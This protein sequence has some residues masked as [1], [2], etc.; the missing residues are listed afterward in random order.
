MIQSE[1]IAT[2]S[3]GIGPSHF[4][5]LALGQYLKVFSV[6]KGQKP[7][8]DSAL[9]HQISDSGNTNTPSPPPETSEDPT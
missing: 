2:I 1:A 7:T 8:P 5:L 9:A 3:V 6:V 4:I